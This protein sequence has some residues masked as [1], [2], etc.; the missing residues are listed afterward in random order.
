MNLQNQVY[1]G[2]GLGKPG[3]IARLNPLTKLS[4]TVEGAGLRAGGFCKRGT[5]PETQVKSLESGDT[6]DKIAGA[7]VFESLQPNFSGV[8]NDTLINEGEAVTVVLKGYVYVVP[9]T[10]SVNGQNVIVNPTTGE[11]RTMVVVYTST[12]NTST[13][14]ITT[15]SNITSGFID[16]FF[17]VETGSAAGEPCE[18]YKL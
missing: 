11:I 9:S 10:A 4:L 5:D 8:V 7:V 12:A 18:I 3:T 15:N 13:G 14:A 6:A 1:I 2:Q 16:T 17:K